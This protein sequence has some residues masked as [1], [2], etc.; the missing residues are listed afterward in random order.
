MSSS[1]ID[2]Q[3]ISEE[4]LLDIRLCDLPIAIP[5]TWLEAC[6]R[7][8]HD[9]L[10]ARSIVFRPTCYL[11]DEWLT[12][13]YETC[14]GIPFYLAHPRL[15]ALEK[16][17]LLEAEGDSTDECL[18]LLRHEAG[19]A[20]CYAYR[21]QHKPGWKK[22]FGDSNQHYPDTYRFRPYSK[23]YVRHLANGYAQY[24][25]DEDFVE[26]FAVWLTP[27]MDW[28]KNYAGWKALQKLEFV[29]KLMRQI[30]DR[31]VVNK[32]QKKYW[33]LATLKMTLRS[34]YKRKKD[35]W[36]EELPDFHDWQ[37][38][39]MFKSL[40]DEQAVVAKEIASWQ[41]AAKI[42]EKYREMIQRDVS[43]CTGEKQYIVAGL[44]DKISGRCRQLSL[45]TGEGEPLAMMRVVAYLTTLVMN[46]QYTGR[47]RGKERQR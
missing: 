6:V 47:Y 8:V 17:M 11:A 2:W 5:G 45:V 37:L 44:L 27:G 39:T 15:I 24:H 32:S 25:P 1:V 34:F 18:K 12:P 31:P 40:K 13:Q 43:R 16:K 28:R 21:L 35:L 7:Q 41:A 3:A 4:Q 20:L 22:M 29:D 23:S 42:I 19:H 26:T 36:A 46:Y 14:I 10:A 30:A 38:L 33:R 9:E